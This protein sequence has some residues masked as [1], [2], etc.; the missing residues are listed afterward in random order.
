MRSRFGRIATLCVAG[1]AL[2]VAIAAGETTAQAGTP[3]PSVATTTTSPATTTTT[4][5]SPATTTTTTLPAPMIVDLPAPPVRVTPSRGTAAQ[6]TDTL[7]PP[8]T[9]TTTTTTTLPPALVLPENSGAGRRVVYSKSQM[10]V[11]TVEADGNVSKTHAVS[12]RRTWNLP[13]AGT[14]N[15]FSRSS[16]TCSINNPQVCWRYMVRFTKGPGGD[17]I[18][19]H[20]IPT[21]N[22]TGQKLQSVSQLGQALSAG[23]VRQATPDAQY[24]WGWAP[25]GT[26]VV[27]LD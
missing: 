22:R 1:G 12:G 21:D 15:V 9:T 5:T 10:R 4:T 6:I 19:F 13:L 3:T 20:E 26:P 23:C 14:Y 27:V 11:W 7:P 16:Y 2:V 24:M 17:N 18:G 8:P 25:I